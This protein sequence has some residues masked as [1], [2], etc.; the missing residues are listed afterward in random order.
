MQG[1]SSCPQREALRWVLKFQLGEVSGLTLVKVKLNAPNVV[2]PSADCIGVGLCPYR[3]D[4]AVRG[5]AHL[6]VSGCA[7]SMFFDNYKVA[8]IRWRRVF[9][10]GHKAS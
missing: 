7:T 4:V 3:L 2:S 8:N 6:I 1:A 9:D 5:I 10:S